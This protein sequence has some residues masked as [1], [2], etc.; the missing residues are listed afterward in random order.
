[1]AAM[2]DAIR[3]R[4]VFPTAEQGTAT[5]IGSSIILRI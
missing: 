2:A 4:H 1:L 5:E 3:A